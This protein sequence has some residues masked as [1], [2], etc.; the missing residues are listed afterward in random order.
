MNTTQLY[1]VTP[2]P[3]YEWEC[4]VGGL[5]LSRTSKQNV[6]SLILLIPFAKLMNQKR[7][8]YRHCIL[9]PLRLRPPFPNDT[10]I[11]NPKASLKPNQILNWLEECQNVKYNLLNEKKKS[12]FGNKMTKVALNLHTWVVACVHWPKHAYVGTFL[13]TQLGFQKYKKKKFSTIMAEV[14]NESHIV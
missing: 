4:R 8:I 12:I 3:I 14:L 2:R 9:Y 5:G 1:R 6:L 13:L 7:S 10:R 11:L